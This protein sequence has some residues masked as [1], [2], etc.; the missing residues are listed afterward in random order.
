MSLEQAITDHAAALR[1]LAAAIRATASS[2]SGIT[3]NSGETLMLA[4]ANKADTKTQAPKAGAQ[5]G[6]GKKPAGTQTAGTTAKAGTATASHSDAAAPTY[7]DV[8]AKVLELSKA[9]GREPTV[10]LLQRYGVEKAPDLKDDQ[11]A[12]FITD[13]D[14]ILAGTYNPEDATVD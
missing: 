3:I 1:E 6:D 12:G 2:A 14:A 8:K 11:Y 4:D 13:V 7:D 9:K 5:G 10:A